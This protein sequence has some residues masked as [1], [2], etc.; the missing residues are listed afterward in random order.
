MILRKLHGAL[1]KSVRE[2]LTKGLTRGFDTIERKFIVPA[3][4][5]AARRRQAVEAGLMAFS[6]A[7]FLVLLQDGS[8]SHFLGS[9]FVAPG[10]LRFP[11]DV[12]V[13]ALLLLADST[14]MFASWHS[15]LR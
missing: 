3:T 8:R 9:A 10:P 6:V 15:S 11:F 2:K 14:K 12:L 7:L 4:K 5:R 13:L 1:P